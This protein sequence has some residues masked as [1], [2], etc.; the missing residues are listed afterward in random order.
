MTKN[1]HSDDIKYYWE[2]LY[3][4]IFNNI[5]GRCEHKRYSVSILFHLNFIKMKK[6]YFLAVAMFLLAQV[7]F[8]QTDT[9]VVF[10]ED[11]YSGTG[12]DVIEFNPFENDQ[13][14]EDV[15]AMTTSLTN[16][17]QKLGKLEPQ[18]ENGE[19]S[20]TYKPYFG[21]E[22]VD[23]IQGIMPYWYY[24]EN[25]QPVYHNEPFNV[26]IT[27][28]PSKK[29]YSYLEVNNIRARINT[30]GAQFWE[31]E[32][33]VDG[34]TYTD[35]QLATHFEFPIGSGKNTIF[36]S[37]F[38]I[39]GTHN[40][41]VYV[42]AERYNQGMNAA[43][44]GTGF[45]FFRG[46]IA[47]NYDE[48]YENRWKNIWVLTTT[49]IDYHK[50][51]YEDENYVAINDI[52][53][54]P[55]HGDVSNGESENIA[56]F[57]D[58]DNDGIYNPYNGDYPLIRGDE[59]V[60]FVVNDEKGEHTESG[61][62][63]MRIELYVMAYAYDKVNDLLT[64]NCVFFHYDFVNRS[65]NTYTDV[66]TGMF[67]DF[68]LGYSHDDYIGS[69][70]AGSSFYVY[71][72]NEIDGNGE[73]W[74]YG[75]NVPSQSCTIL[76][77]P[78]L[79]EDN[80][81]NENELIEN[82]DNGFGWGDG[83]IDNERY[84]MTGF[85]YTN[86]E[87]DPIYGDPDS[88]LEYYYCL[89]SRFLEGT[90]LSYGADGVAANG[91]T[92]PECTFAFPGDSD[93]L[94]FGTGGIMPNN[95]YNQNGVFWTEEYEQNSPSDRRGIGSSGPFTFEPNEKQEL[96]VVFILAEPEENSK[97]Q[98]P[99]RDALRERIME[100]Q[101]RANH[102]GLTSLKD[103]TM[104]ENET[105]YNTINIYPNPASSTIT[106]D[107]PD[108]DSNTELMITDLSGRVVMR[109][110]LNTS[111]VDVSSLEQGAY[112]VKVVNANYYGTQTLII[113]K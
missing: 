77:G 22:G 24:D 62:D 31:Y 72:G 96:D 34:Y 93:P 64:D 6:I 16:S 21:V 88:D 4:Y 26:Y 1:D 94:N 36:S 12:G 57:F 25:G 76:A 14:G 80:T 7:S 100:A 46:P 109:N 97:S 42:A 11:I 5:S 79:D 111:K 41:Q 19:L 66:Y 106:I 38:W 86:N 54:W 108:Y 8:A 74:A 90:H 52:E 39:G 81:D 58:Y 10:V 89:Q 44:P 105:R 83:I 47:D 91:A 82:S 85:M 68:D 28:E 9:I 63:P 70:V 107:L 60:F 59:T 23:T 51:H 37:N 99:A 75:A 15:T 29:L 35:N 67:V 84:G 18:N 33:Y 30:K 98:F 27:V 113:S 112:V 95:G 61:G 48:D 50:M 78:Y 101:E 3:S 71:N 20:W 103:G 17:G 102:E 69:D 40:D 73:A 110:V 87:G 55:A 92:G 32:E 104:G 65:Q 43:I 53:T 45:D 49:D 2:E 13:V 56:P